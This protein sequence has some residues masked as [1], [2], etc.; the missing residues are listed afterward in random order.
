MLRTR[1][2]L[3]HRATPALL[4]APGLLLFLV[5]IVFSALRTFWISLHAWDGFGPMT[6]VGLSN[7]AELWGDPQFWV[8]LRNNVIWLAV[9]LLAPPMGLAIALLVNQK[10]RTMRLA[11]SLFFMPLVLST[12][13][14]GVI[15]VWFYDPSYGLL[16]LLFHAFGASPPAVLSS[17]TWVTFAV[18]FAA[19]WPQVAFCMILFLAGLN[20]LDEEIIGAGRVDNARG[21]QMLR[22]IV[23]PQLRQ[24][25]FI[26]LAISMIGALRS[27][28]IIAVMTSGGPFGSSTNL[29]YQ[30]YQE[31]LFS[32]RFGYGAALATV[33]F[34]IMMVFIVWYLLRLLRD[35]R[36]A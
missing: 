27:F 6:W 15:F 17:D 16:A 7:Y 1:R 23:L 10:I 12:V 11:K 3:R 35:E 25:A 8:S 30:M 21:W 9:F 33:L 18:V 2:S 34:A 4:L 26:A 32:Y 13:T 20:T 28:D 19:L 36:S 29:A 22:H 24:V 5:V 31:S 14:V